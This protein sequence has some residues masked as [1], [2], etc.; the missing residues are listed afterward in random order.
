MRYLG[1]DYGSNRIGIAVSDGDGKIA[2]PRS[3]IKNDTRA[4]LYLEKM[5][6]EERIGKIVIGDTRTIGG[7]EN[8]ITPEA[9]KF[10]TALENATSL[11]VTRAFEGWSSIEASRYAPDSGSHDDSAAAAIILQRFFDIQNGSVE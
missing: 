4:I 9:E 11:P 1:I 7:A 10:I 5:V 3:A 6:A 8:A 2:F